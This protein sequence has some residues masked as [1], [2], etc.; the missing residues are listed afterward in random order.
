MSA[1]SYRSLVE[2]QL[3]ARRREIELENQ[4]KE[5]RSASMQLQPE[6]KWLKSSK[7]RSGPVE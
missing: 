5:E 1:Q 4:R 2:L 7:S 3:N 6:A